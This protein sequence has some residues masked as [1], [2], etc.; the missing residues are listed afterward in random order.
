METLNP[1]HT[2]SSKWI[3]DNPWIALREDQVIT[4]S[5]QP[6]IYGVIHYKNL[7]LGVIPVD[8]K[9]YTYLVGQ[10]RYPLGEYSWEIPEGGGK[11]DKDPLEEIQRELRE[12]TGLTAKEWRLLLRMHLSNSVSDELALI[13]LAWNLDMGEAQPEPTEALRCLRLPLLEAIEWVHKGKITD[14][15]SVAGL[16]Y[17][18]N[19]LHRKALTLPLTCSDIGRSS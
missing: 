19:L 13:Y 10:Y 11:L 5:G 4:P 9:G 7:A 14:S 3:Y 1:W 15:L 16:L 17:V 18:E 12:E 6:G 2:L 8:E